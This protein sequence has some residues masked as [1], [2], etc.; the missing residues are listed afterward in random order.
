[1]NVSNIMFLKIR[2]KGDS[3]PKLRLRLPVLEGPEPMLKNPSQIRDFHPLSQK[4]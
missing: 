2:H 4:V 3:F 1:M